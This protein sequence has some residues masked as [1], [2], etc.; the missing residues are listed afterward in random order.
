MYG[1]EITAKVEK[2]IKDYPIQ[3]LHSLTSVTAKACRGNGYRKSLERLQ[4]AFSGKFITLLNM[5]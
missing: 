5:V 4:G 3:I 2:C 1:H